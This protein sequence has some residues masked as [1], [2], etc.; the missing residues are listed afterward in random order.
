MR[1]GGTKRERKRQRIP[2]R[3]HAESAKPYAELELMNYK[4]MT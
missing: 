3:L 4:I 1:G 2:S